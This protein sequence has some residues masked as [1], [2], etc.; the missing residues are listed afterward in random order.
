M[1]HGFKKP[2]LPTRF[3]PSMISLGTATLSAGV[4]WVGGFPVS[5]DIAYCLRWVVQAFGLKDN[6]EVS[7]EQWEKINDFQNHIFGLRDSAFP[8]EKS[9]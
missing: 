6:A 9:A 5:G 2:E 8:S 1:R 4:K 3:S 7:E